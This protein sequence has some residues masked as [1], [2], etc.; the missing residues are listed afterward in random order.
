MYDSSE[1]ATL[2]LS[3]TSEPSASRVTWIWY[4]L[5]ISFPSGS[6][7]SHPNCGAPSTSSG[8]VRSP[9]LRPVGAVGAWLAAAPSAALQA[10]TKTRASAAAAPRR[11]DLAVMV[12]LPLW[13][14]ADSVGCGRI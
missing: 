7:G 3:Q 14:R 2:P 11:R 4:A 1:E 5:W 10:Q 8:R 12:L 13:D 6:C 9:T